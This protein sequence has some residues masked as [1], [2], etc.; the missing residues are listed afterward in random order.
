MPAE[1]RYKRPIRTSD[2]PLFRRLKRNYVPYAIKTGFSNARDGAKTAV[3]EIH[4]VKLAKSQSTSTQ[5]FQLE[6]GRGSKLGKRLGI[7]VERAEHDFGLVWVSSRHFDYVILGEVELADA[8]RC[9]ESW[10]SSSSSGRNDAD[11]R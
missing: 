10:A 4:L 1:G 5:S 2:W 7:H 3:L 6:C 8:R 11:K 9:L